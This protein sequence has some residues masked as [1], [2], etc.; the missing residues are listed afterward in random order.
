MRYFKKKP[1]IYINKNF[2]AYLI[3]VLIATILWLLINLNKEYNTVLSY[4]IEYVNFP[5]NKINTSVLP[6]KLLLN[7]KANGFALLGQVML[8]KLNP[9]QI[10]VAGYFKNI[11]I[12]KNKT[13]YINTENI[14]ERIDNQLG[15]KIKA[16]HISPNSIYFNFEDAVSKKIPIIPELNY[17]IK[18]QYILSEKISI[19]PDSVL[20]TGAKNIIDTIRHIS[21]EPVELKNIHKE[22][23]LNVKLLPIENTKFDKDKTTLILRVE[24]STEVHHTLPVICRNIPDSLVI[25][26]FPGKITVKYEVALSRYQKINT[27]DFV[28]EVN[29]DETKKSS[30]LSIL[31]SRS[32]EYIE[33]I[34]FSPQQVDYIIEKK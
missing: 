4:K 19:N 10:D 18:K 7:V 8:G 23:S 14:K 16:T 6:E 9:I 5:K 33:N 34:S 24:P 28:F 22:T 21:T 27:K 15:N 3:C 26:L 29:Y 32:P 31:H 1:N 30:K 17:T 2:A 20:I 13:T 25:K 12:T 11:G